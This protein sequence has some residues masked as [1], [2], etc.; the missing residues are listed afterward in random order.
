MG[1]GPFHK[2]AAPYINQVFGA[3]VVSL[4]A[5]ILGCFF[6]FTKI[7]DEKL[8]TDPKG[9]MYLVAAGLCAF[10]IDYFALKAY[11]KGL[12]ITIGGPIIIGGSIAIAI[13]IGFAMRDTVTL[14]KIIAL[15]LLTLGASI[16]AIYA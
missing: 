3:I 6:L 7:K 1:C 14:P 12:P 13:V 2:L 9:V 11:S 5:V 8:F 16:L 15:L 4:T 10:C